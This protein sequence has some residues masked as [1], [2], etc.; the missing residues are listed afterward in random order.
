V[1]KPA[2]L[3]LALLAAAFSQNAIFYTISSETKP[4]EPRF[5]NPTTMVILD[6]GGQK[7][8]YV[9][10]GSSLHWYTKTGWEQDDSPEGNIYDLA[11]DGTYLYAITASG[12]YYMSGDS[13]NWRKISVPEAAGTLQTIF[14]V[15]GPSAYR[16]FVGTGG[17]PYSIYGWDGASFSRIETG[18]GMLTGAAYNGITQYLSTT[19]HIYKLDGT[20][21]N[22]TA[23]GHFMGIISL[24]NGTPAQL[25]AIDKEG[26]LFEIT[27]TS[28]KEKQNMNTYAQRSLCL[29]RE[30]ERVAQNPG[31]PYQLLLAGIQNS[32]TN[33][34]TYGYHEF[35]LNYNDTTREYGF[36][37][38]TEPGTESPSSVADNSRYVSSIGKHA[39]NYLIQV[40]Y[41]IDTAMPLF[42]ATTSS[43]WSYRN[44]DGT[45]QWNAED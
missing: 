14:A 12:L 41:E 42:A 17:D 45:F 30:P 21:L 44:R 1:A 31:A 37:P 34:Y 23:S 22:S 39:V 33:A 3:L 13:N 15:S 9:G 43:L 16:V 32:L 4:L 25:A 2:F 28:V 24:E 8:L 18:T 29:W 6:R 27:E 38:A 20:T 5:K 7:T 35:R 19:E 10:S 26:K 40:P 36:S 11:A